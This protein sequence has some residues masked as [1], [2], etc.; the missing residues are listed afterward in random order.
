VI[1]AV[2]LV[3]LVVTYWQLS[4]SD[5]L[6]QATAGA[7]LWPQ[8]PSW[9]LRASVGWTLAV[10]LFCAVL[11]V[12]TERQTSLGHP[13]RVPVTAASGIAV[14]SLAA[15]RAFAVSYRA[16]GWYVPWP[17]PAPATTY[18]NDPT[19][20]DANLVVRP[21]VL[22]PLVLVV[23]VAAVAWSARRHAQTTASDV[24]RRAAALALAILGP[25]VVALVAAATLQQVDPQT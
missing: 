10:L 24:N 21:G 23:A 20:L 4:W 16:D 25:P 18:L 5:A 3:V 12:S 15:W 9:F 8:D 19:N 2:G 6:D 11:W 22:T 17:G 13:W 1:T 7:Y 14:W